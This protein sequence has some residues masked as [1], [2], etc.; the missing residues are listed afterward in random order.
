MP[1][2]YFHLR[3]GRDIATD[4]DGTE[5]PDLTAARQEALASAREIVADA[6]KASKNEMP[7][8]FVIADADGNELMN[9]RLDEA[10]PRKLSNK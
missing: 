8:C 6:V 7:D 2:F 10:L 4:D 1:R 5:L 9:V 3:S